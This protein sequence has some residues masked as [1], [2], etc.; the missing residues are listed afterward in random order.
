MR[1]IESLKP[2]SYNATYRTLLNINLFPTKVFFNKSNGESRIINWDE[3]D[4]KKRHFRVSK[5]QTFGMTKSSRR[6]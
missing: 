1:D 6:G 4:C 2:M 3:T 5:N